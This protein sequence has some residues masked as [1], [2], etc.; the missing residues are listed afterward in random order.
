MVS[1]RLYEILGL[2]CGFILIDYGF[3]L[4]AVGLP[5]ARSFTSQF[6]AANLL[7][8]GS[9]AVFISLFYLLRPASIQPSP[10]PIASAASVPPDVGVELVVEEQTGPQVSFYKTIEYIGYFFTILGLFSAADLVLQ[11]FVHSLYNEARWWVEI[12]LVTFGV[13]AYTIFGSIGRVGAQEEANLAATTSQPKPV[14]TPVATTTAVVAVPETP[15][16]AQPWPVLAP[17]PVPMPAPVPTYSETIEVHLGEFSKSQTGE[18][19]H[20][21]ADN[22]Y[23]MCRIEREVVTIWKE[24]R[25]GIRSIYLSG[26]YELKRGLLEGYDKRGED[27]A[28]GNLS[29]SLDTIKELLNLQRRPAGD[30]A[31]PA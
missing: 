27:L 8:G 20:Q 12:L 29:L 19:V 14:V 5:G 26:P 17:A 4:V 25:Q 24:E 9:A 11:I 2:A 10:S 21:L 18:Y 13:L 1:R 6:V 30:I 3:N 28:I 7:I 31:A 15:K 16:P 23:D 22:I